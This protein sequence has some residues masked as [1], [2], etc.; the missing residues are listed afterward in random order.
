MEVLARYCS[1]PGYKKLCCESCSKHSSTIPPSFL[2]EAAET[3]EDMMADP[4]DV[5]KTWA[6]PTSL[7]PLRSKSVLVRRVPSRRISPVEE[8]AHALVPPSHGRLQMA[9]QP[10]RRVYDQARNKT[11]GPLPTAYQPPTKSEHLVNSSSSIVL[12]TDPV[13]A[14]S[15]RSAVAPP[16]RTAGKTEKQTGRRKVLRPSTVER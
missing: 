12:E 7:V 5:P 9:D 2:S 6:A 11:S 16:N 14:P 8:E 15:S 13:V 4:G 10:R 3:E 1:I